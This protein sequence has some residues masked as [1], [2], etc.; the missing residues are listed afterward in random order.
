[1]HTTFSVKAAESEKTSSHY[2][3]H[4]YLKG[5]AYEVATTKS[6]LKLVKDVTHAR[7]G[8]EFNQIWLKGTPDGID[9]QQNDSMIQWE[10]SEAEF[11]KTSNDTA[12]PGVAKA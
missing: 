11:G 9:D 2:T 12:G 6:K 10:V 7:F 1:M 8:N 3:L 4:A 5:Q